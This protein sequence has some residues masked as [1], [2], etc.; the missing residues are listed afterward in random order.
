MR[1]LSIQT[2]NITL[3][4]LLPISFY[5]GLFFFLP[6]FFFYQGPEDRLGFECDGVLLLLSARKKTKTACLP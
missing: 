3:S 6:L 2:A 1:L 4:Q 5:S